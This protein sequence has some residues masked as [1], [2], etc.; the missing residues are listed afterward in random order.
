MAE[1]VIS[2]SSSEECHSDLDESLDEELEELDSAAKR[3]KFDS[4]KHLV[5]YVSKW[6]EEFNWLMPVKNSSGV[7]TGM[8]CQL[9]KRHKTVSKFNKSTV[10]S[11]TPC[12]C[13]R[14]DS[15][16]RHSKSL[17]HKQAVKKE[18]DREHSM[19]HGSIEQ[20]FQSQI[21][22]NKAAVKTAMQTLYWLVLSEI[23]HT[24]NYPSLIQAVEFMGC[25][26]LKHLKVWRKC[27]VHE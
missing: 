4:S 19:Q 10:W 12:I 23:P 13:I 2:S 7:V 20:A 3:Q 15:V 6:E 22:L 24:T 21:E 1:T 18:V 27:T 14:K 16:R 25:S 8:L 17:Q 5:A 9:C 26:Q 11:V